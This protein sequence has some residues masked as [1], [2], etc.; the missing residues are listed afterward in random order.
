[1]QIC[2]IIAVLHKT[3]SDVCLITPTL[4]NADSIIFQKPT[5]TEIFVAYTKHV[6]D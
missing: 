3:F 1:M 4:I 5:Y 6:Y 2:N